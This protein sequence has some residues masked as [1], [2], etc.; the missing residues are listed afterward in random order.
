M[1]TTIPEEA[2]YEASWHAIVSIAQTEYEMTPFEA[3]VYAWILLGRM[4][5]RGYRKMEH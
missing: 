4:L 1:D 3:N 5:D 2:Y